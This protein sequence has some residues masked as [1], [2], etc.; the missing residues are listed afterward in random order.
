MGS[1]PGV[2]PFLPQPELAEKARSPEQEIVVVQSEELDIGQHELIVLIKFDD[3]IVATLVAVGGQVIDVREECR[4][5]NLIVARGSC[6]EVRNA[7]LAR[8]VL[9]NNEV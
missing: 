8:A 1:R 7:R 9:D 4:D 5:V 6:H 2:T 3:R